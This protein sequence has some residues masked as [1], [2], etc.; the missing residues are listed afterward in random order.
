MG[1]SS[2]KLKPFPPALPL[3][4][5]KAEPISMKGTS[6]TLTG[7]TLLLK[8]LEIAGPNVAEIEA[9]IAEA[10]VDVLA[11]AADRAAAVVAAGVAMAVV[12]DTAVDMAA[13]VAAGVTKHFSL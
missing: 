2:P 3:S 6:R 5:L 7:S 9:A 1:K 11:V 8:W 10:A 13:V 12:E 4:L